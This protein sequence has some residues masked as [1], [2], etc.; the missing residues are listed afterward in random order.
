MK[1]VLSIAL[2]LSLI[3]SIA[4][5]SKSSAFENDKKKWIAALEKCCDAKE[6]PEETKES[7]LKDDDYM[8][9]GN[10]YFKDSS[11]V[12]VTAEDIESMDIKDMDIKDEDE[13]EDISFDMISIEN[14][15]MFRKSNDRASIEVVLYEYK[16]VEYAETAY[17]NSKNSLQELK[18]IF[19]ED[20]FILKEKDRKTMLWVDI[21]NSYV[22][23]Q[24]FH[25]G[26]DIAY[27]YDEFYGNLC[28]SITFNG[29][30]NDVLYDEF[31]ELLSEMN[32]TDMEYFIDEVD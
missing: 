20:S 8:V 17:K 13:Y 12:T 3:F 31:C 15:F 27:S 32:Y 28:I 10:G 22:D 25:E 9:M 7:F 14:R 30:T 19:G 1:R 23:E 21:G 29:I 26:F 11:Y 18:G 24:G 16:N 2:V 5:C 4:S 6:M